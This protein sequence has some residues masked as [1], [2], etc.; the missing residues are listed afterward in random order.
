MALTLLIR[1][2]GFMEIDTRQILDVGFASITGLHANRA[3]TLNR[4][5]RIVATT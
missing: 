4:V 5:E 3:A 1:H 2:P